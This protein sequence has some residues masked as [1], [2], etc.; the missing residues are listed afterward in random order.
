VTPTP[1]ARRGQSTVIVSGI[2][3]VGSHAAAEF[4]TSA[5]E[6]RK[7]KERFQAE[8]IRGFPPAYQVVVRCKSSDTLLLSAE[9]EAHA[10]IRK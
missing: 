6:L 1:G 2:T 3:S 8:G 7:M 5:Q 4:F 10:T 9:Y